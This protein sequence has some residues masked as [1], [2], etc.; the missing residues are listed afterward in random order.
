MAL[1]LAIITSLVLGS[2]DLLATGR[3]IAIAVLFLG[4]LLVVV[5]RGTAL[6]D[7]ALDVGSQ[8]LFVLRVLGVTVPVAGVALS[9]GVSEAVAAFFVGMGF[10]TTGHQERIERILTPV[11]DV[12]AAVFFFWIGVETDPLLLLPALV[13]LLLAIVLTTP[14]KVVSGY[15]G[16]KAFGLPPRRSL[17]VGL[18]MVS[19][20]EFSLVIAAL[21]ASGTGPVMTEVIPAFAVGYVLAMSLLGTSLMQDSEPFERMFLRSET[22]GEQSR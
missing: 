21:A 17:R 8:E 11:R 6:F 2:D 9:L 14:A 5:V 10:S 7:Q 22:A 1:Y 15:Y 20:G 12:F 16:G 3:S 4:A 13:P 19:R 18:G